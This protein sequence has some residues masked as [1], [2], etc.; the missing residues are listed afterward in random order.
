MGLPAARKRGAAVDAS[1]VCR[2]IAQ[3]SSR[4]S[5]S[6][7]AL[8]LEVEADLFVLADVGELEQV[9]MNLCVNARDAMPKGGMITIHAR[10]VTVEHVAGDALPEPSPYIQITVRDT[11]S[12]IEPIHLGRIF[13]PFF[14]TKGRAP[15]SA[16]AS[17]R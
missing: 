12:G 16:W 14:T 7:I 1:K 2:E 6:A 3:M 9:L 5:G 15:A 13:E 4:F 10:R 17:R 11:G 8:Q